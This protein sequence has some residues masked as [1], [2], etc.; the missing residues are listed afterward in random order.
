MKDWATP[1]S[2]VDNESGSKD[3]IEVGDIMVRPQSLTTVT[4]KNRAYTLG[5]MLGSIN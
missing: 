2:N 5:Y 1:L 4:E 3:A